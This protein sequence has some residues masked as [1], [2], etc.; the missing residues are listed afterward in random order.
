[1]SAWS[2]DEC[3]LRFEVVGNVYVLYRNGAGIT[4]A[5]WVDTGNVVAPG[6]LKRLAIDDWASG[7]V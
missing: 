5:R 6:P 2:G 3:Q 1:M 7:D 4:N